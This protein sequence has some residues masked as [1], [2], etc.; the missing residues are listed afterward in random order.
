MSGSTLSDCLRRPYAVLATGLPGERKARSC[1]PA[2]QSPRKRSAP[3]PSGSNPRPPGP[4]PVDKVLASQFRARL[5]S[6]PPASCHPEAFPFCHPEPLPFCHPE[7]LPFCH[8]ERSEE[9]PW[10]VNLIPDQSQLCGGTSSYFSYHPSLKSRHSG[11]AASIKVI[12]FFR[13][14]PLIC[15]SLWIAAF[16]SPV[17]S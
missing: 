15:F 5:Y 8:S 7:P 12:F 10:A 17:I 6:D 4:L 16:T 2:W 1:L 13:S 11:F 14:H 9:S 3:F